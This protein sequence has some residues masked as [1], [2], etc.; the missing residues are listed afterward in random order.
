MAEAAQFIRPPL[1]QM[2]GVSASLES[3]GLAPALLA[4]AA[5]YACV[6]VMRKRGAT[7]VAVDPMA[8]TLV[9]RYEG[10]ITL[11]EAKKLVVRAIAAGEPWIKEMVS[12]DRQST[13][14]SPRLAACPSSRLGISRRMVSYWRTHPSYGTALRLVERL[15]RG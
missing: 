1:R 9:S 6:P 4:V 10:R 3:S 7:K 12:P 13:E 2:N 5:W 15:R 14:W 8:K 11:Q